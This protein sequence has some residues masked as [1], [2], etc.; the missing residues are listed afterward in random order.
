VQPERRKPP[1]PAFFGDAG[2]A[3]EWNDDEGLGEVIDAHGAI[4]SD[5]FADEALVAFDCAHG[6]D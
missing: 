6:D 5:L 1:T 2:A 4:D 3:V